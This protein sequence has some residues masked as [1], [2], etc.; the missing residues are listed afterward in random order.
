[1]AVAGNTD[2]IE[3][4]NLRD[5]FFDSDEKD[6]INN[7]L[8]DKNFRKMR[9]Q[10][11]KEKAEKIY[12]KAKELIERAEAGEFDETTMEEIEVK[13]ALLLSALEEYIFAKEK[14]LDFEDLCR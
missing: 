11:L 14:E 4:I 7:L 3:F 9:N 10:I 2:N 1:M 8:K 12:A 5:S 13:I 6:F